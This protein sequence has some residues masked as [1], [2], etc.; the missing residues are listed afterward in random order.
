MDLNKAQSNERYI[1]YLDILGFSDLVE[2]GESEKV[3]EMINKTL[4][5]CERWE[6]LNQSFSTI[7]FSDTI[8]FYQDCTGY[9]DWV[10]LDVYAIGALILSELLANNIP[11]RGA[12][13]FGEFVV[14]DDESGKHQVYFGR[15]FIDVYRAE[16]KENW[17]GILILKSAWLP[18][19][20]RNPGIVKNFE[21]E[22]VWIKRNDDVLL[23]NPFRNLYDWYIY[24]I[25][26]EIY[27]PYMELDVPDFPNSIRGFMFLYNKVDEYKANGD[28]SS[29]V[30][31]KYHS[32]I[33]FLNQILGEDICEWCIRIYEEDKIQKNKIFKPDI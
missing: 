14:R 10:F 19:E 6:K 28:F 24:D 1:L 13:G 15:A 26:G 30:A 16:K 29:K 7:Y 9:Y 2:S 12:I 8:I 32:T 17:I 23:L 33:T 18:Y 3:Y 5:S 27:C 22:R 21:R 25:I 20:V 11:A 4:I 31:M